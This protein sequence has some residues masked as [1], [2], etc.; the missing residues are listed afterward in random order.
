MKQLQQ[1][2]VLMFR[3]ESLPSDAV[4]V[5]PTERGNVLADGEHTGHAHV[6][7]EEHATLSRSGNR[8]FLNVKEPTQVTHEEH[9]PINL[10]PGLWEIGIV[11]E[12]DYLSQMAR[13]VID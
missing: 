12:Y 9:K 6:V 1:G 2:D 10:E 3:V 13:P 8:L 5:T 11:Q 7:P 4:A